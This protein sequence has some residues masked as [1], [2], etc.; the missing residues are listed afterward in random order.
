MQ[1][2]EHNC[3]QKELDARE[4][5]FHATFWLCC[6]PIL[7]VFPTLAPLLLISFLV[8]PINVRKL[9]I[10]CLAF[11]MALCFAALAS[12]YERLNNTGDITRYLISF[13]NME[14]SL[15][16]SFDSSVLYYYLYPSW[17]FLNATVKSLGLGFE[18]VTFTALFV[19]YF[20]LFKTVI[21]LNGRHKDILVVFVFVSLFFSFPI[22]F[23]SYRTLFALSLMG[24]G[25]MKIIK[26]KNRGKRY[27]LVALGIHPI[28]LV[29]ILV[30]YLS[31][32]FKPSKAFLFF[33]ILGGLVMKPVLSIAT[34]GLQHIPI[35]GNKITTYITGEWATYRFHDSGEYL[36][37]LQLFLFSCVVLFGILNA[38]KFKFEILYQSP[39]IRFSFVY[40]C[41]ALLFMSF[42]TI[43]I[44]LQMAGI[45]FLLPL[46]LQHLKQKN[47]VS[48]A[49]I[50]AL[51]F[52]CLDLRT[53]MFFKYDSY[54]IGQGFPSNLV[55]PYLIELIG[56]NI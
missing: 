44:R 28:A 6:T 16:F 8:F 40:L 42:R 31:R 11:F 37:V 50:V 7:L 38:N 56:K 2:A 29:P 36:T 24:Y 4:F 17:Y 15:F 26:N 35:I 22:I 19:A 54:I 12:G 27:C 53:L 13:E 32:F 43:F 14:P 41:F 46:I 9:D 55:Q 25:C 18:V 34:V 10:N 20:S 51:L 49:L 39:I 30:L 1:L 5:G 3:L 52:L 48:R 33:A 21:L 23:S 45:V 47:W